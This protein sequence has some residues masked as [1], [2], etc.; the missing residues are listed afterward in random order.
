MS[1]SA[2]F[3]RHTIIGSQTPDGRIHLDLNF[4]EYNEICKGLKQMN[5]NREA[6]RKHDD[7]KRAAKNLEKAKKRPNKPI[8]SIEYVRNS[9]IPTI[10]AIDE[11]IEAEPPASPPK[12]IPPPIAYPQINIGIIKAP[13]RRMQ[14]PDLP[15]PPPITNESLIDAM[16]STGC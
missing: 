7:K 9:S 4:M 5:C 13:V 1:D 15:R 3:T 6:Q 16:T 11:E 12:N 2:D 8:V 10:P 14:L